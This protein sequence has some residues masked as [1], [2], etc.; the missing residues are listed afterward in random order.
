MITIA[1]NLASYLIATCDDEAIVVADIEDIETVLV[2]T[3]GCVGEG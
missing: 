2:L 1:E 3:S